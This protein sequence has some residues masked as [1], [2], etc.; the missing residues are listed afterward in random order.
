[1]LLQYDIMQFFSD[2]Q[3][4]KEDD[5][6]SFSTYSKLHN[7]S[8]WNICI[9]KIQVFLLLCLNIVYLECKIFFQNIK[10]NSLNR[11]VLNEIS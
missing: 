6:D 4:F 1:M 5:V 9:D 3:H 8:L 2:Y 10:I 7:Q 11:I